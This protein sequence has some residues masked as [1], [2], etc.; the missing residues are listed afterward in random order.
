MWVKP[1]IE[2]VLFN[3]VVVKKVFGLDPHPLKK[4]NNKYIKSHAIMHV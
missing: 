4:L 2:L 1:V 3:I